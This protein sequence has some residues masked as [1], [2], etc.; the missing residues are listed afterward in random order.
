MTNFQAFR[1]FFFKKLP[2]EIFEQ[3]KHISYSKYVANC[4]IVK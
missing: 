1:A 3:V 4:S 2:L